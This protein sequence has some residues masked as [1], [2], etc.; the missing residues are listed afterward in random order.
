MKI[1]ARAPVRIDP[2]GGGTDAPPYSV[3]YGGCVVNFSVAR[4]S[5]AQLQWLEPGAGA[6]LYSLDLKQG[7]RARNSDALESGGKLAFIKGFVKRLLRGRDDF[8]LVTQSDVP[9]RTGLGGSG[10][11]GVAIT[12]ACLKAT[13]RATNDQSEVASLANEIE[14]KDLA[15]AGGNQDSFGAAVGGAKKIVLHRGGGVTCTRLNLPAGVIERLERDMLLIYTGGIHLSG[16]IHEDIKR[17]YAMENSPTI[18]AMDALKAAALKMADALEAGD[19]E[20]FVDALNDSRRNHY[21]LHSSCDSEVLREYFSK[22]EP[23]IAGGKT[24]GAGGGG[25]IAVM[26]K[27]GYKQACADAA[28]ALGGTVWPFKMDHDGA[29]AWQE[30]DWTPAEISELKTLARG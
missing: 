11:M 5:Y 7:E 6:H 19:M 18:V 2:A 30:A 27:P 16:T 24:C 26:T 20:K 22:L 4:Y 8:L 10:A 23:F 13:G 21:A 3:E 12:T 25:F 1:V 29:I 14:R 15:F 28:E 9:V 17:S